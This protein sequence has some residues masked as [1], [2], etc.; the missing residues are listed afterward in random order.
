[1]FNAVPLGS[2]FSEDSNAFII[3]PELSKNPEEE[4]IKILQ[5]AGNCSQCNNPEHLN[6]QQLRC[7]NVISQNVTFCP[8]P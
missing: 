6:G 1:M 4:Y 5:N 3:K 2:L 7:Q 8:N